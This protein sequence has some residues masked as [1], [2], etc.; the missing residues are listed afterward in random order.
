MF[1]DAILLGVLKSEFND[2]FYG[3]CEVRNDWEGPGFGYTGNVDYMF[4]SSK[5]KSV[6]SMYSFLLVVEAK[7]MMPLLKFYVNAV[8][9]YSC[10]CCSN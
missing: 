4:G 9:R 6:K 10:V 2:T 1:I 3:Y 7:K 8:K 5:T